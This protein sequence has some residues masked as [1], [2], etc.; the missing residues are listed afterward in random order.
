MKK[1]VII[2]RDGF[3]AKFICSGIAELKKSYEITIIYE[4][5]R[6]AV[7]KKN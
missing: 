7:K 6:V 3:D 2:L 1:V 5:G 4:T